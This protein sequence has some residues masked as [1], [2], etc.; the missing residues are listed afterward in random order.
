MDQLITRQ[1]G[2]ITIHFLQYDNSNVVMQ[3]NIFIFWRCVLK[4]LG[5]KLPWCLQLNFQMV[6]QPYAWNFLQLKN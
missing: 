2:G 3:K 4:F 1:H 5:V 6:Q